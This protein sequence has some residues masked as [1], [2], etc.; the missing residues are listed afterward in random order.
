MVGI[1]YRERLDRHFK[2]EMGFYPS[3]R[4]AAQALACA[5]GEAIEDLAS[6]GNIKAV[7]DEMIALVDEV[8]RVAVRGF[9]IGEHRDG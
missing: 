9:M 6:E 4:Q 7:R 5:L 3:E 1:A 8:V 2:S